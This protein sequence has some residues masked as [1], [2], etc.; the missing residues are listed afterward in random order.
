MAV[1][2]TCKFYYFIFF[3]E[4]QAN[5]TALIQAS[6][7]ELTNLILSMFGTKLLKQQFE[8]LTQLAFKSSQFCF[9]ITA[10][11]TGSRRPKIIGPQIDV[12]D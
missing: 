11:T 6:V 9:S 1:V 8:S 2:T 5:L 7:P 12:I 3:G 4:P 10:C